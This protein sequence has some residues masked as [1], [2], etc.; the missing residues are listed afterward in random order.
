MSAFAY[1]TELTTG[2]T[3]DPATASARNAETLRMT[4]LKDWRYDFDARDIVIP[5][6]LVEGIDAVLQRV[7]IRVR[8]VMGEWFLDTRLGVPYFQRVLVASPDLRAIQVLFERVFLSVPEVRAVVGVRLTLDRTIR[9]LRVDG[10]TLV[11]GDGTKV[12]TSAPFIL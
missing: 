9:R 1:T 5:R 10:F 8:F 7:M 3:A 2:A 11:L 4:A 12:R 6:E